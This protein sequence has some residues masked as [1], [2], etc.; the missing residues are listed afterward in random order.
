MI[1]GES[2]YEALREPSGVFMNGKWNFMTE[3]HRN[4]LIENLSEFPEEM[5]LLFFKPLMGRVKG[6]D[7][8]EK[9]H[10]EMAVFPHFTVFFS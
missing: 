2:F 3:L 9:K 10:G 5:K 4:V 6:W 1:S 7:G 8:Y